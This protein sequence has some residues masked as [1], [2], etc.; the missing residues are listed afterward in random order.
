MSRERFKTSKLVDDSMDDE[1]EENLLNSTNEDEDSSQKRTG[2]ISEAEYEV[3]KSLAKKL[4]WVDQDEWKRDPSKWTPA[5]QFLDKIP[6]T[7]SS[8]KE[9]KKRIAQVADAQIAAEKQRARAEAE[10]ELR[11]AIEEG[12]TDLAIQ[13]AQKAAQQNTVDPRVTEWVSRNSWFNTDPVA[14]RLA[15]AI[16]EDAA[17]R[18]LG[19]DEQL[20]IAEREIRKRFPEHFDDI[21]ERVSEKR[22]ESRNPPA[23]QSGTRGVSGKSRSGTTWDDIPF[24]DRKDLQKFVGQMLG[25]KNKLDEKAAQARLAK[26]YWENKGR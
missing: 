3:H 1:N 22:Y 10:A 7:I 6:E 14:K 18:N 13:A 16:T 5:D 2:S 21:T 17:Q 9:S 12:D 15:V 25:G 19:I 11:R 23:V 8:L 26:S 4:G 20:E 24:G